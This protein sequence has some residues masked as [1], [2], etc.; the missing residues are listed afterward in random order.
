MEVTLEGDDYTLSKLIRDFKDYENFDVK[1]KFNSSKSKVTEIEAD[2]AS[3]K[4]EVK[5]I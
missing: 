3:S 1:L 4:R 2:Y 5:A